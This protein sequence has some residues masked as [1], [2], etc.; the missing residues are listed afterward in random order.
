MSKLQEQGDRHERQIA[1]IR[2]LV[3]EGMRMAVETRKDI[4]ALASAQRRTEQ[5]L[6]TLIHTLQRGGNGHARR[7]F[8][9]Q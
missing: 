4:R 5:S 8:D 1:A 3:H 9:L 7:K 6:Q 2:N